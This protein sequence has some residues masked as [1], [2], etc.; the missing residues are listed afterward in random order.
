M[1]RMGLDLSLTGTGVVV[2]EDT[3]II[4]QTLIV[5]KKDEN[6]QEMERLEYIKNR[7]HKVMIETRF[8]G[9]VI[10]RS[11]QPRIAIEGPNLGTQGKTTSIFT[12]GKL[13]GIVEHFLRYEIGV[14]YI[15]IP[16]TLLKKVI[17][18]KGQA[19]KELMMKEAYKKF[20]L[21]FSDNNICDAFCLCWTLLPS[22]TNPKAVKI[23]LPQLRRRAQ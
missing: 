22:G 11:D 9:E 7:I 18:G 15:I 17:T 16:P 19:K 6:V 21:D 13:N 4:N 2:M 3:A 20:N 23:A 14:P 10:E 1:K 12:L 8:I 5:T